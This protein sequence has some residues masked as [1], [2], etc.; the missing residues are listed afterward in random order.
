ML[1]Q[2]GRKFFRQYDVSESQFNALMAL[3]YA[4]RPLSQQD[5]SER[6]LVDKSNVTALVD[7]LERRRLVR[8]SAAPGD[9]RYYQINLTPTALAFFDPIELEYRKLVH[10][11]MAKFSK[12]E[13]QTLCGSM[14]KLQ[15][16]LNAASSDPHEFGATK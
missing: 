6:L 9:R 10:R 5:L 3:K 13:M 16:A 12:N 14:L 8:R 15:S 4:E 1:R 11:V 2:I 7:G